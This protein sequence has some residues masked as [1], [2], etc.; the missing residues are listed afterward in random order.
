MKKTNFDALEN[1]YVVSCGDPAQHCM[2]SA[3]VVGITS[4][5]QAF[6]HGQIRL[7]HTIE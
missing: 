5:E 4:T 2:Y 7:S 6:T 3:T 1:R